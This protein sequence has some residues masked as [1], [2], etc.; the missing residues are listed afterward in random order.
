MIPMLLPIF[1]GVVE[2]YQ[3]LDKVE[4]VEERVKREQN[5]LDVGGAGPEGLH[6]H[7]WLHVAA[8]CVAELNAHVD[9][10]ILIRIVH[11]PVEVQ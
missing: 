5:Q 10:Y 3:Q 9:E 1:I 4:E 8:R 7:V 6:F 11:S 2:L